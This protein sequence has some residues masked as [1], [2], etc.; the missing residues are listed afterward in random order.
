MKDQRDWF[1]GRQRRYGRAHSPALQLTAA[2]IL[3]AFGALLFLDNVGVLHIQRLYAYWPSIFI[4]LGVAKLIQRRTAVSVLWSF[5]LI[6]AGSIFLLIN[7]DIL[8]IHNDGTW[9]LA[10]L[11]LA[12]GFSALI[13][14][15]DRRSIAA[16]QQTLP[17]FDQSGTPG[18]L[19]ESVVL[20]SLKRR[21]ESANFF[22]G[23]MHCVMGSIELDLHGAQLAPG[24]TSATVEVECVL[25]SIKVRVPEMWRVS[26]QAQS[27]LGNVEDRTLGPRVDKSQDAPT[28]IFTGSSVMSSLELEN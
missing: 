4:V 21:V 5:F 12:L 11:F 15:V 14:T 13:K 27:V 25:G 20:G 22:G 18:I 24:A 10:L 23:E 26:V 28:L 16:R 2:L 9:P 3:I 8:H 19:N 6:G 7:L 17:V 1:S